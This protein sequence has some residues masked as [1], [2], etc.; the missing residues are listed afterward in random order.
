MQSESTPRVTKQLQHLGNLKNCIYITDLPK[1]QSEPCVT[2]IDDLSSHPEQRRQLLLRKGDKKVKIFLL[3]L[4]LKKGMVNTVVAVV[5]AKALIAKSSDGSLR[6]LDKK[7]FCKNGIFE[8]TSYYCRP[9]LPE[10]AHHKETE[11]ILHHE[12]VSMAEKYSIPA[13]LVIN[14]DQTSLGEFTYYIITEGRGGWVMIMGDVEGGWPYDYISKKN[15]FFSQIEIV[16]K[17]KT[18]KP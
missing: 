18:I 12:I 3:T 16:L 5:V 10:G 2:N 17:Q 4:C 8:K 11:L 13:L 1:V 6:V 14:I 15:I 7:S 9:E